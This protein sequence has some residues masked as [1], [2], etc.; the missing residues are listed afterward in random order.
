M[1]RPNVTIGRLSKSTGV[2]IETIRYYEKIG[3]LPHPPRTASGYRQY[4]GEFEKRLTFVSRCREL[5]FSLSEI[6][7]LLELVDG[8]N[9]T[10]EEVR[11]ITLEHKNSVQRKITDL[12]RLEKTLTNISKNCKGTTVPD[13][14]IIEALFE[15]Q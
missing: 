1:P 11:Q 5:G 7:T 9:Y 2:H 12:R 14:P 15:R 3:L 10:C 13:C 8:G 4:D 6:K